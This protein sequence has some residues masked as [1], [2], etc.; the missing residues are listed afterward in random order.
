MQPGLEKVYFTLQE[1]LLKPKVDFK[2]SP[3]EGLD[4]LILAPVVA[5][6]RQQ[7][8]EVLLTSVKL[9]VPARWEVN[10]GLERQRKVQSQVQIL[11]SGL[12]QYVWHRRADFQ[13]FDRDTK[14][15]QFRTDLL[16]E[17]VKAGF[18]NAAQIESPFGS[19]KVTVQDVA[20]LEK[21][22]TVEALAQAITLQRIQQ[23]AASVTYYANLHRDRFFKNERWELPE[24]ILEEI[25]AKQRYEASMLKD[26]WGEPLR[27]VRRDKKVEQPIF[28]PHF[29]NHE[30]VSAGPDRTLFNAD[31]VTF[32]EVR[33]I[34]QF[35]WL[36]HLWWL[37]E[38]ERDTRQVQ[39][40]RLGRYRLRG[41][42]RG[43][44]MEQLERLADG[45]DFRAQ[46]R[47]D[48]A[49]PRMDE[50]AKNAPAAKYAAADAKGG[51]GQGDPGKSQAAGTAPIT[52]VREYFPETMLWQP[53]L[54]TDDKGV[55]HLGVN[56]ADSITTWRLSASAN[57]RRRLW[58]GPTSPSRSS[59]TSSSTSI[60]RST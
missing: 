22:F 32:A 23:L 4:N 19:G 60:C 25:V 31:D 6:P 59:R 5:A 18:L 38:R 2:F 14:K 39:L 36:A 3:G 53:A 11:G 44:D 7:V 37:D 13:V 52:K 47:V 57:S 33:K 40:T 28:G 42:G 58:A 29:A 24:T 26:A 50:L 43:G 27:L 16:D 51:P 10:P 49:I 35:G 34:Q 1:E 55:A 41:E 8:A 46:N 54:I 17:A 56:F 9:P 12:F 30:I 45:D 15:W 20:R 21:G 48:G